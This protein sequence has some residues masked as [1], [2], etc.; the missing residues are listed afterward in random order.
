MVPHIPINK[1]LPIRNPRI[2]NPT[3]QIVAQIPRIPE[4]ATRNSI[5]SIWHL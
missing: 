1:E 4:P 5:T 3:T 2:T